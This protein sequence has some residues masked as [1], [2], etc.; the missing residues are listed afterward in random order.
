VGGG[1]VLFYALNNFTLSKV[2]ISDINRELIHTYKTIRDEVKEL[3]DYLTALKEQYLPANNETREILYYQSRD[4]FN[5]LKA[6]SSMTTEIA[7]LFI[8]LNRLCYNG[9]YRV[10]S[11]G[12]F[13]VP[14]GC[15]KNPKIFDTANLLAISKAIKDVEIVWG[16]YQL[17]RG[18]IDDKTFAYFDPPYRPL[19]NTAKFTSYAKDTFGDPEQI[20]LAKFIDEMSSLGAYVL[21]SNSDPKNTDPSDNFFDNL[22]AKHQITRLSASRMI[23]SKGERRGCIRE[24]LISP[25]E[26]QKSPDFLS[27]SS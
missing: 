14:F 10:N 18:F 4:R 7:A 21:A 1:A 24:I 17:A 8:F 26:D 9:L 13:N 6:E 3:I 15:Y 27:K 20:K 12:W 16:D 2:Y 23:N 11:K 25:I 22:Y 5:S 19:S